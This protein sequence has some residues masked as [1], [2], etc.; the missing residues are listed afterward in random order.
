VRVRKNVILDAEGRELASMFEYKT[1]E[2][3]RMRALELVQGVEGDERKRDLVIAVWVAY[4]WNLEV[5]VGVK[6]VTGRI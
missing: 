4:M 1:G 5:E 2:G 6:F 3:E